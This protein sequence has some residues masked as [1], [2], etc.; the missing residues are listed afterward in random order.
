MQKYDVHNNRE[1]L[2]EF[3]SSMLRDNA[4][5]E[6]GIGSMRGMTS[7]VKGIFFPLMECGAYTMEEKVNIWA[8]KSF[9]KDSTNLHRDMLG[10]DLMNAHIDFSIPIFFVAGIYD[11]TVNYGLQREYFNIINAPVKEFYSFKHSAHSPIFEEPREFNDV[12]V[13]NILPRSGH[14]GEYGEY[15]ATGTVSVNLDAEKISKIEHVNIVPGDT[16]ITIEYTGETNIMKF[17]EFMNGLLLIPTDFIRPVN[18]MVD[19]Y[20]IYNIDGTVD[21][22]RYE[23]TGVSFNNNKYELHEDEER[24]SETIQYD[25]L[26]SHIMHSTNLPN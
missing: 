14:A 1:A 26:T 15:E 11:Y 23:F 25:I 21:I 18:R 12:L 22:F 19:T 20:R 6:L 8:A 7:V 3:A 17:V 4:M 9:L 13:H 16:S 2:Y 5:H 10:T 24:R